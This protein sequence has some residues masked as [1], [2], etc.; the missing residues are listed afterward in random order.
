[1]QINFKIINFKVEL[2]KNKLNMKNPI[3]YLLFI[4]LFSLNGIAQDKKITDLNFLYVDGKYDKLVS[5]SESLM[6]NDTYKKHPMPYMYAALGLYEMSKKPEKYSVGE[7]D[8]DYP[9]PLKDAEKYIYKYLKAE[10]KASKY[11]PDYESTIGDYNEF[12]IQIADTA[13]KFGQ[14]LFLM[15]EYRKAASEYKYAYRSIPSDPVLLLW[16]GLSEIKSKNTVEG[17]KNVKTALKLINENFEPTE[18]TKGVLANGMLI[19]EEYLTQNGDS[20]GAAKAKKLVEVFKKYDPDELDKKKMAER[21]EKA[22]DA[23][24][25]MRKFYSDENDEDNA[26]IK[27]GKVRVEGAEDADKKLDALEDEEAGDDR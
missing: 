17:D 12:F 21:K 14:H 18:A 22:K 9:K 13:N 4:M 24:K 6:E 15:E 27:K 25:I 19:L 5:K 16:Q 3:N 1:M 7:K 2:I 23:D 26:E 20:E 11:F 10:E 8:S